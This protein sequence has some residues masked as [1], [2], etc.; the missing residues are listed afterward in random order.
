MI[1]V[2]FIIVDFTQLCCR[3]FSAIPGLINM[4]FLLGDVLY[5][6][7]IIQAT[8]RCVFSEFLYTYSVTSSHN[9]NLVT[10]R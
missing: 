4:F 1:T 7:G 5:Y 6:T 3:Y 8:N 10:F 2:L 9:A